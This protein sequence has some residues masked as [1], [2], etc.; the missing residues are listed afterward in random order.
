[1]D[2]VYTYQHSYIRFHASDMILNID[3]DA[4]YLVAPKAKSRVAGY[5]YLSFLPHITKKPRLNGA[6]LVE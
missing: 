1:M 4:A 2:Y 5:Y 6:I 3:S